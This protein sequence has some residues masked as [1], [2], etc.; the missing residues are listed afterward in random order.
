MAF[1]NLAVRY[2]KGVG[3]RDLE[4]GMLQQHEHLQAPIPVHLTTSPLQ[5]RSAP[6]AVAP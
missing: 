1:S 6:K 4:R 5:I 3:T 2:E